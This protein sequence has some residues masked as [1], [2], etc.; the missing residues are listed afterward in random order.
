M[1]DQSR[2]SRLRLSVSLT[3]LSQIA[4]N[5]ENHENT[6]ELREATTSAYGPGRKVDFVRLLDSGDLAETVAR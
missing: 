4:E 5:G 6:E 1:S 2:T 3:L